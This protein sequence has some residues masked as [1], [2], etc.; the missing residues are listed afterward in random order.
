MVAGQEGHERRALTQVMFRAANEAI[1]G[2]SRGVESLTFI[3]ECGSET[4]LDA[5][6]LT[7]EEYE[8]VRADGRCFALAAGHEG[9]GDSVIAE[10]ERFTLVEKVGAGARIAMARNPRG[11]LED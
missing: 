9:E 2:P 7:L 3:C 8:S 10:L 1:L 11:R 5:I 4:C 6:Q